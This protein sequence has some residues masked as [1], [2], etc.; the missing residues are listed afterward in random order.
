MTPGSSKASLALYS[1]GRVIVAL[2]P[3]V[4]TA[5]ENF[6]ITMGIQLYDNSLAATPFR[7]ASFW[8]YVAYDCE[9]FTIQ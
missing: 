5:F 6:N 7:I 1:T 9:I 8:N 3:Y 4:A 2:Y